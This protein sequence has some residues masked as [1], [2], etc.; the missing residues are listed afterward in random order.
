MA[1]NITP[2]RHRQTRQGKVLVLLAILLPTVCGIAGL[3]IDGGLMMAEYR[4]AQH[5][6]DAASTATAM[7]L[8]QGK[9]VNTATS[10]ASEVVH[11]G[12]GLPEAVVDVRIPPTTGRYVGQAGYAEVVVT[13]NYEPRLLKILDGVLSRQVEGRA[14][15]GA[16]PERAGAAIVVLDPDPAP[17]SISNI[18]GDLEAINPL[19]LSLDSMGTVEGVLND[20][21]TLPVIGPMLAQKLRASLV[22]T[23]VEQTAGSLESVIQLLPVGPPPALLAGLEVEGL[24]CLRVD[25]AIHVNSEWG[26][27]DESGSLVGCAPGPPYAMACTPLLPLTRVQA[28]SIRVVGGVDNEKLYG[29]FVAGKNRP[30]QAGRLPVDDPFANLPI[31]SIVTD[32]DNVSNA[33]FSSVDTVRIPL[34]LDKVDEVLEGVLD[35]VL[36]LIP[37]LL[38][39]ILM[40][41]LNPLLDELRFLLPQPESLKPGVYK[42]LTVISPL[43]GVRFEPGVYVIR[44]TNELT[45]LSLCLIGP[46]EAEGVLFYITRSANFDVTTGLPDVAQ[47]ADAVP[48]HTIGTVLPSTLI[49]PLLPS[50]R[51]TGLQDPLSPFDGMLIYQHRQ[52]RRPIVIEAQQLLGGGS[53]SGT[54]YTKWGHTLFLGGAGSYDLRFVTG[55]LRVVTVTNTTIAPLRL[56]PAARDILLVE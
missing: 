4:K 34:T 23:L 9:D 24:G 54:I 12:H 5:A 6:A 27:F 3:V 53:L 29:P 1:I 20:A 28:R 13:S 2:G 44:G 11:S 45:K 16:V 32:P 10:V 30:L 26:Q 39:P 38:K 55:T 31:P 21:G 25:G 8:R 47:P 48:P 35:E 51:I 41:L 42:S 36:P 18:V 19:G 37:A 22:S 46:M 40:P 52:D 33:Y 43:G 14:V 50:G 15:A 17:L 7:A 56:L 49:A